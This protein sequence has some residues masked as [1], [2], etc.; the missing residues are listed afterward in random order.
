[1][2]GS[3]NNSSSIDSSLEGSYNSL[4][5]LHASSSANLR[6][7]IP[8]HRPLPPLPTQD[9]GEEIL[10][11]GIEDAADDELSVYNTSFVPDDGRNRTSSP[12]VHAGEFH[13]HHPPQLETLRTM[14]S[15]T[16]LRT[17]KHDPITPEIG[18]DGTETST[19]Q[20]S[21]NCDS[22]GAPTSAG[23]MPLPKDPRG[24]LLPK[25]QQRDR[26]Q[27]FQPQSKA[28]TPTS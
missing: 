17:A 16:G 9:D 23:E 27:H 13:K 12:G 7:E 18:P 24:R 2:T 5:F 11:L 4:E 14:R 21:S 25:S 19:D 3:S 20:H 1:M 22:M 8:E 10:N 26:F 6:I 15:E 28:L